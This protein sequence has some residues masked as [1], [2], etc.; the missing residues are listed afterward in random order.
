LI[1][2]LKQT[3]CTRRGIDFVTS[4]IMCEW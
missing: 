4:P 2:S 1:P 3:E